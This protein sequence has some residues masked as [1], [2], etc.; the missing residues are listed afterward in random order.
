M[1][2]IN[3]EAEC[4]T[5]GTQGNDVIPC[6]PG[7]KYHIHSNQ[8]SHGEDTQTGIKA[9]TLMMPTKVVF[10]IKMPSVKMEIA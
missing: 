2:N 4:E 3:S 5:A 9:V 6:S 7:D 8:E 1:S 10:I